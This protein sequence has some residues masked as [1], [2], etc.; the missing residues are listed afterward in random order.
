M[1][2]LKRTGFRLMGAVLFSFILC[3]ASVSFATVIAEDSGAYSTPDDW[4]TVLSFSPIDLRHGAYY[5]IGLP[6]WM[7][8]SGINVVFHGIYNEN[9]EPNFLQV[10][11]FDEPQRTGLAYAGEDGYSTTIPDWE[12]EYSATSLGVWSDV[13]GPATTNDVIFSITDRDLLASLANGG[14]FGLGIDPD[15]RFFGDEITVDVPVPEPITLLLFGSGLVGLA[16][17][18]RKKLIAK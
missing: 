5:V 14:L 9:T 10:W 6:D 8:S 4:D 11:L 7:L 18:G 16:G 15:C 12:A 3:S 17:F 13:D 1:I 2:K